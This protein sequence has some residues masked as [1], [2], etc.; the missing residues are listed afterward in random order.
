LELIAA[1]IAALKEFLNAEPIPDLNTPIDN[2]LRYLTTMKGIAGNA[3]NAM[4]F[5][6]AVMAKRYLHQ[7]LSM[8]PFDVAVKAQGA[9]GLDIDARTLDGKRVIGEIKTTTPYKGSDLGAQQKTTFRK[10]FDKL[11]H[12]AAE[13]KFF[14]VTDETVFS[15]MKGKYSTQLTGVTVVLLT[16]GDNL[17]IPPQSLV[18]S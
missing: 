10:D 18:S 14:F 9:P 5:V 8:Q 6:A 16:T 15:L 12:G 17:A 11:Q 3:S 1:K 7:T 13:Y 4:S 2:W